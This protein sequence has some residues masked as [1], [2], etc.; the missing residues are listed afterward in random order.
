L[1]EALGQSLEVLHRGIVAP[2]LAAMVEFDRRL[3][4][5]TEKLAKL[6]TE[7]DV[8]AWK[9]EAAALIRDLEKAGVEGASG[10]ADSLKSG[11]PFHWDA[12]HRTYE[13]GEIVPTKLKGI[14]FQIKE[15]VQELILKDLA[16]ARD[17]AT[18]P[19]FRELVD[20]YYEVISK[21]AR[22]K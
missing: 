9:R 12:D 8:A 11:G 13:T 22:K 15:R 14:S 20:R 6:K 7:A 19:E 21:G 4:D 10:M 5:L 2:E 17:E 16:S 3:A 18:P 1:L